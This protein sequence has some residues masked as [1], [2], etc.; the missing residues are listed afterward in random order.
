M[1]STA[2][3]TPAHT[4]GATR[5]RRNSQ[6][7]RATAAGMA[8]MTPAD[9]AVVSFTPEIMHSVN[10]KLPKRLQEQQAPRLRRQRRL[11]GGLAQPVRM[12]AAPMPKRSQ[13]SRKTGN[14]APAAWTAP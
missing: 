11:I 9:T 12:A 8:A 4:R 2:Q 3:A 1:P 7:S 5:S 6:L 13:A 14:M 10:R